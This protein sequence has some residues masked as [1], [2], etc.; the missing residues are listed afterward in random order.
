MGTETAAVHCV[1]EASHPGEPSSI[2][3]MLFIDSLPCQWTKIM[4]LEAV[5]GCLVP[6][7]KASFIG[8]L[9]LP[10][11]KGCDEDF[12][13]IPAPLARDYGRPSCP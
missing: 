9:I 7:V 2:F 5:A 4:S 3:P 11:F 13:E 6:F 1:P 12:V 10:L 8:P